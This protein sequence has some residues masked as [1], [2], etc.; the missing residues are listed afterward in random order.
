M[1]GSF[2]SLQPLELTEMEFSKIRRLVYDQCGIYLSDGKKELV[3]A[4]LNQR[5]KGGRFK[6]FQEYYQYIVQDHS[7]QEL[8][9]LLDSISTNFTFFFREGKHFEFLRSEFIPEMITQ[10]QSRMKKIRFWS[11]GCSSGEEAYSI[12]MTVL[13]TIENPRQWEISILATD[14]STKVLRIAEQ[15]IFPLE[16]IR[17]IPDPLIRKYFL[18]GNHPWKDYVMVKENLKRYIQFKRLNLKEPFHFK[19]PFDCI[20]CRNVMIYF[21]KNIQMK[22]IHRFYHCL[23]EGGFLL[24]GHSESLT[25][26]PHPFQYVRPAI[27]KK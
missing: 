23:E 18:K 24:I 25:G 1:P 17:S 15:G 2:L 13:E 4:R 21:D 12:A 26:L 14:L 20:F 22:L 9:H 19:E 27:Y 3:K 7:G 11:A 5:I 6:S 10:K 8:I 16:R